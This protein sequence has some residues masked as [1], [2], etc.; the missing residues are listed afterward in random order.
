EIGYG[1]ACVCFGLALLRKPM[2][3]TV[4]LT[5][6]LV[7]YWPLRRFRR[8]TGV[9]RLKALLPV[10]R[11]KLPFLVLSAASSAVT[12]WAQKTGGAVVPMKEVPFPN[13][14]ASAAVAYAAYL[15]KAFWPTKLAVPYPFVSDLP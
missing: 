13:R 11:E 3:V 12:F 9:S 2:L 10:L 1:L 14:L 5:L 15:A 6:L 8:A 4:P 7:D